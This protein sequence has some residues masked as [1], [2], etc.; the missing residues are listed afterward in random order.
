MKGQGF[1]AAA[2]LRVTGSQRLRPNRICHIVI[3]WQIVFYTLLYEI[4]SNVMVIFSYIVNITN[5]ANNL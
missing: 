5:I 4:P 3:W 1:F 2:G